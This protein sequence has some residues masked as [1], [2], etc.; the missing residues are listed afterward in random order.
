VEPP[1]TSESDSSSS[2][3]SESERRSA[4]VAGP[5]EPLEEAYLM[6]ETDTVDEEFRADSLW[7]R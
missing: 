1:D 5:E 2:S 6:E 3:S 4:D 7:D